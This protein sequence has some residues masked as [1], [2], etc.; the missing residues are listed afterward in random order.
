MVENL[1]SMTGR[2][3]IGFALC[4]LGK[5]TPCFQPFGECFSQCIYSSSGKCSAIVSVPLSSGK[6]ISSSSLHLDSVKL[7]ISFGSRHLGVNDWL[8]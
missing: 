6:D 7:L 5:Y 3:P 4:R 8:F 2:M 1:I